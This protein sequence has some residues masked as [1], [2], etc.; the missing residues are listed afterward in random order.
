M[1]KQLFAK[2]ATIVMIFAASLLGM[3]SAL[4]QNAPIRGTVV[5]SGN[6]PVIGAAVM[7][8]GTTTGATTNIDGA[9]ELRV[10]PGTTLEVSCIGY[11]TRRVTAANG[12]TVVLEDD[13]EMLE[14]TVVI[15]YGVQKK[16]DLTG[17]VA[18]VRTAELSDRS[19]SDA[20]AALQGKAAGVQ[21]FNASGAPGS[22]SEIRVRGLSSNGSAGLGPLLI[23]DGLKVDNIQYLDP[24]MIESIEVLKDAASA[25]IYGAQAGNGVVLITTKSGAN[26]KGRDGNIFYNY[27]LTLNTVGKKAEVMNAQQYIDWNERAGH[28][29]RE[30]IIADG[31]WDGKTETDWASVV[32]GTGISHN[33]TFGAQ[34]S[35]DRGKYYISLNYTD[36]DGMVVGN[37]DFYKRLTAQVN[38]DYKIKSWF[39]VGTNTSIERYRS[40]SLSERS[41]YSNGEN[42]TSLLGALVID[43]LT[44]V[45]YTSYDQLPIGMKDAIAAGITVYRPADHPDWYYATSKLQE[46]DGGN[47]LVFRDRNQS[48]NEGWNIRGTVF[49]NFTPIKELVI[50]SRLG[51]RIAQ[52][53]S[54]NYLEPY[55]LNFKLNYSNYAITASSS[56]NYYYQW[57][58]FANYNKVFAGKHALGVMAGMSYTFSDRRSVGARLEGTDPLKGYAENFRYISQDNG[59]GTKSFS[60]TSDPTQST[61]ISYFGRLTYSFDNRYSLQANFRADAFDSSKLS[62]K[63]RWGYFPS[64]SVGWTISNERFIKDNVSRD[65]LNLLK[66]RAS[67]G[68]NGNIAVLSNYAYSSDISYNSAQYQWDVVDNTIYNGSKPSGLANPDLTWETSKQTDIGLDARF[69]NN[70]LSFGFDWYNKITDGLLMTVNPVFEVG[71]GSTQ[72]NA[73]SIMNRGVEFELGW[74]DTVG[75][76]HY[77]INAN[78]STNKNLV[79]YMNKSNGDRVTGSNFSNFKMKTFFEE[80]YPVWYLR[81]FQYAGPT[82]DGKAQFYA[83]DGTLTTAPTDG[84]MTYLGSGLPT[85]NYGITF[86]ADWKGLDFVL[87]GTGAGG[88]MIMPCV[89]RTEHPQINS[90]KYFYENA[91]KTLPSIKEMSNNA[92][93]WSS[94][95]NLFKGDYFKIKQ[96]QLGYT[97]PKSWMQKIFLSSLRIYVSMDDWFTFTKYPGFDPETVSTGSNSGMGLDKGSYPNSKKL[98]FG[99]NIMF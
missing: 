75:D 72:R 52:S 97:L 2:A 94:D 32:F 81:G 68:I 35:N 1:T 93:F 16:S 63:N 18:S 44:P 50:T 62:T 49:A 31:K 41:E 66:I 65:V 56:Q 51:Y 77:S 69:L 23:V 37:K 29:T 10:A 11:T 83:A 45:Y 78:F 21:I 4:A 28:W 53:Y 6:Q 43:P 67:W 84:D 20:A 17:S 9:F 57:E 7:V 60:G 95:A 38:A 82:S 76:F 89:F 25:A 86:R 64:V 71:A 92:D 85:Y 42:G 34:G 22:G 55:Y 33:H 90:L 58:N 14:E 26:A 96:I 30:E 61:Q 39:Q 74:Q 19:T 15:G 98:L 91:D 99:V 8:P 80:G 87:F 47:P 12:M 54:S 70:R 40:Q 88:N 3:S 59:S 46:G 79:T 73:G 5:D 24:A 36:Q 13:T 48:K 27:K